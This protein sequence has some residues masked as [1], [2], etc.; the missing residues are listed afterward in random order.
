MEREVAYVSKTVLKDGA[1]AQVDTREASSRHPS[2]SVKCSFC[3]AGLPNGHMLDLHLAE[4]HDSFFA[5]Q[6]ARKLK[7]YRCLVESCRKC[8]TSPAE[9]R[10]HLL[11]VHSFPALYDYE[12]M[13]V[14]KRGGQIRPIDELRSSTK[15]HM[16]GEQ[17][18]SVGECDSPNGQMSQGPCI[19]EAALE[20]V[21]A[22]FQKLNSVDGG[23]HCARNVRSRSCGRRP[24]GGGF[25]AQ[26]R[27][28]ERGARKKRLDLDV[29]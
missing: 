26:G 29:N 4:V 8:F 3:N 25:G 11:Q 13:H 18:Q 9:R 2:F 21:T 6:A 10:Q 14:A 23:G 12:A 15:W 19:A 7:V 5:A 16:Q 17:L 24:A 1:A 27:G 20:H 28:T 22:N